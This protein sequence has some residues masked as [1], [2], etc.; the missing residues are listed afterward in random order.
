MLHQGW[1]HIFQGPSAPF[2]EGIKSRRCGN[3]ELNNIRRVN[4]P[5]IAYVAALVCS[6][7]HGRIH[8][9]ILFRFTFLFRDK[10]ASRLVVFMALGPIVVSIGRS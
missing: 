1:L 8:A 4:I 10:A 3:A 9:L 5:S 6:T 7:P 2:K